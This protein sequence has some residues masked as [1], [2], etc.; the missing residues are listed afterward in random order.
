[1]HIDRIKSFGQGLETKKASPVKN[2]FDNQKND[3]IQISDSAKLKAVELKLET[4]IQNIAK[5]TLSMP[6]AKE[7]IDR[8]QQIKQQIQNKEYDFHSN[9]K[10]SGSAESFLASLFFK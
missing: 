1:M 3:N 9:E 5:S 6:D 4:D 7:R 8:V 10:L 2:T